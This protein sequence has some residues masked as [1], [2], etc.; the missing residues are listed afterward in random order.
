MPRLNLFVLYTLQE[1]SVRSFYEALGFA[2]MRERHGDGPEHD[3]ATDE[4]GVAFEIYHG[5]APELPRVRYVFAVESLEETIE[6]L[7]KLGCEVKPAANGWQ[8][9]LAASDPDGRKVI[10]T[11]AK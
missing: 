2:F 11:Q 7:S 8:G 9:A 4:R 6:R 10:V 3:V 5:R 1:E